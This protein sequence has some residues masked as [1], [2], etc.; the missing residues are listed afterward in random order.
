MHEKKDSS[1]ARKAEIR[2]HYF[3]GPGISR[4]VQLLPGAQDLVVIFGVL[5]PGPT[6]IT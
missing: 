4:V 1:L 6:P 5:P 2:D 3:V